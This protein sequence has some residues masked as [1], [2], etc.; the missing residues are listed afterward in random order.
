M[1][2][3]II[4]DSDPQVGHSHASV[5]IGG[6]SFSHQHEHVG[7]SQIKPVIP[8]FVHQVKPVVPVVHPVTHVHPV[9][10]V[11]VAPVSFA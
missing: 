10:P 5:S 11:A 8:N 4:A 2:Y 7:P 3:Q 1:P 6:V 9:A